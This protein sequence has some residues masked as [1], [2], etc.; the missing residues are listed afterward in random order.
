MLHVQDRRNESDKKYVFTTSSKIKVEAKGLGTQTRGL[1][2]GS[3]R[4]DLFILDDLE[5]DE[6]T[7]TAEQIEK[8]KAW[9]NDSMVPALAKGGTVIYLGTILR[10]EERRVGTEEKDDGRAAQ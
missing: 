9:F 7:S 6:S 2:H 5:S 10:S 1:R 3:T 8:A 4:P